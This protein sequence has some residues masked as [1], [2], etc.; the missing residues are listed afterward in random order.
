MFEIEKNTNSSYYTGEFVMWND[1]NT[2]WDDDVLWGFTPSR[3]NEP[4]ITA[5]ITKGRLK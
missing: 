5:T 2:S 4:K 3:T 1:P